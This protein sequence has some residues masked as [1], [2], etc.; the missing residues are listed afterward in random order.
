MLEAARHQHCCFVTLT[1]DDEN[2]PAGGTLVPKHVTDWLKRLRKHIYPV[3][4]RYYAV[5]EYGDLSWRPHYHVALFGLGLEHSE[6]IEK[7]W[8]YGMIHVGTLTRES[9]QYVAGYVTKKMTTKDDARLNGRHPEFARMSKGKG[10]GGIGREAMKDV[11]NAFF[12]RE[13][14]KYINS[15]GDVPVILQHG[16]Q[17]LPL[18]RYLRAKLREDLGF[19]TTGGQAKPM[20]EYS[21]KMQ[22]LRDSVQT[23]AIYALTKPMIEHQKIRQVEAKAK[24]YS[25]KGSI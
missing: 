20:A 1:Y 18:G 9:A 7:T 17:R 15:T 23:R 22:A 4:V 19:E 21:A 5:G 3:K 13:G 8:R 16:A 14:A 11:A 2:L 24:I 6:C 25:K 10:E 12:D